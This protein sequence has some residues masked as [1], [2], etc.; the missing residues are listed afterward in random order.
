MSVRSGAGSADALELDEPT[1]G[2]D[3]GGA[4]TGERVGKGFADAGGGTGD[5][6]DLVGEAQREPRVGSPGPRV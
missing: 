1:R 5:P 3:E 4:G 2:E 6:D